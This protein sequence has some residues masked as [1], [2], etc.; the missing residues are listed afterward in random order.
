MNYNDDHMSWA[1]YGFT[2]YCYIWTA[3]GSRDN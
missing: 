1:R 2:A 3:R